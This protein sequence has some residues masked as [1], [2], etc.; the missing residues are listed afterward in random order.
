MSEFFTN[1]DVAEI[2]IGICL[3][4]LLY[5]KISVLCAL[6]STPLKSDYYSMVY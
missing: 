2:Y 1:P 3:E 6:T 5:G 4:S